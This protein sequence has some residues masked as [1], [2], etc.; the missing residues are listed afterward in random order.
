MSGSTKQLQEW[1]EDARARTFAMVEDL[2][3]EQMSVPYLPTVNPFLWELGHG[4]WFQEYWVLRHALGGAPLID[5]P[6]HLYDS[7][8]V[9]HEMRWHLKMP[10]RA[11]V[12]SYGQ[13][14][15]DAVLETLAKGEP[16]PKL[17]YFLLLSV[18][19]E[20][21]HQEAFCYMR[22][23][24]GYAPP[25]WLGP[26]PAVAEPSRSDGDARIPGGRVD[27]GASKETPFVFDNEKW[28]HPLDI[29]AF[30]IA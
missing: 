10:G 17:R 1:I 6:D 5:D 13:R 27:I 16:G 14:V 19:H 25:S 4:I 22:Q 3:D 29:E 23:T 7:T 28:A 15:R 20:D 21:M 30:R 12:M 18:F 9:G 2:D 24:L 26:V 11:E 8:H